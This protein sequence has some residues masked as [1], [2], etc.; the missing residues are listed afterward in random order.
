MS[1]FGEFTSMDVFSGLLSLFAAII[2]LAYP[3]I[4]QTMERIQNRYV[5]EKVIDWFQKESSLCNFFALLKIN[6]P[7]AILTPFL[8]YLFRKNESLSITLLTV[9]SISICVLL[10]YLMRLYQLINIYGSYLEMAKHTEDKDMERLIIVM[11]SADHR[12]EEDGYLT[13]KDK[14]Y[15]RIA[16]ILIKEA[17]KR[18]GELVD[19][20]GEVIEI[21]R[22]VLNAAEK[23]QMYPRT[24]VDT[25]P[26]S[27]LY[28][29]VYNKT[30][31]AKDLRKFIWY[32]LNRLLQARNTDWLKS[33]WEWAT[34]FYRTICYD[35]SYNESER[36]GFFEMHT[37][38][39]AMVLWSNNKELMNHIMSF[40]DASP[41]PPCLL[42]HDTDATVKMLF[43]FDKLQHRPFRLAEP[44]HMYFLAN[45]VNADYNLYKVLCDYL[46][47]SLLY[48]AANKWDYAAGCDGYYVDT[49]LS[50]EELERDKSVL[51][52]FREKVL[53]NVCKKH[54]RL[55]RKE[56]LCSANEMLTSVK[57]RL[58]QR[59][60]HITKHDNISPAKLQALKDEIIAKNRNATLPLPKIEM[61]GDRVERQLFKTVAVAQ[62]S[63]GQLLEHHSISSVNFAD[64]LIAC[65]RHQ[66][67][68]RLA[69]LFIFN[70]TVHTYLIQYKDLK[71]ALSNMC[72]DKD[73][74]ILFNNGVSL[75]NYDLGCITYGEI[76]NI[77]SGN[78]SLFILRKANCPTYQYGTLED[79]NGT[80]NVEAKTKSGYMELDAV[81]GLYWKEPTKDN[82]LMVDIAQPYILY[83]R[84][85]IRYVK[86]NITYD[87]AIGDCD[88]HNL[89]DIGKIL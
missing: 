40:Q 17:Q 34:Q 7:I 82:N 78:N 28:D 29:A 36:K 50:K 6:I 38:F 70:G 53:L 32:H 22:K 21:L 67:Y 18:K 41:E 74:Y 60:D 75:W 9:Q 15:G 13:A 62:A 77:D 24:S 2:G 80:K 73:E 45:D 88:L 68:A 69:S 10:F 66:F 49:N 30:H 26:I 47:Y 64:M 58:I 57:E 39:A 55:F 72:F 16:D 76:V 4:M 14:L 11:L 56:Q 59:I 65:L 48:V 3:F 27:L 12:G 54:R 23:K 19:F 43:L 31:I 42:L 37:F 86:I 5:S 63:S 1:E 84:R 44:Y 25:T 87:R 81:S 35:G 71:A 51:E 83:S 52:W 61:E 79:V 33:Y 8:L 85:H 89:K 20:P 46:A